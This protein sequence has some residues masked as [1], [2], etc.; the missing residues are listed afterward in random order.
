ML[1]AKATM[2]ITSAS[3]ATKVKRERSG[4]EGVANLLKLEEE[5]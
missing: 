5:L 2:E 1:A 4:T 3:L